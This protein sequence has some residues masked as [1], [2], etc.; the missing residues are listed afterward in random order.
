MVNKYH[1]WNLAGELHRL[2]EEIILKSHSS[3]T[4]KSHTLTEAYW[5]SIPD[6]GNFLCQPEMVFVTN[7]VVDWNFLEDL[8]V[9]DM[10]PNR[11][12]AAEALK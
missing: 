3:F 2:S 4:N 11:R 9:E 8:E 1:G 10:P 6:K 12:E 5:F 7:P